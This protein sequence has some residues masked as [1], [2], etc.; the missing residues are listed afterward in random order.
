MTLAATAAVVGAA[1]VGLGLPLAAAAPL[2][3]AWLPRFP[4]SAPAG[5]ILAA[6]DMVWVVAV[7][8]HAPLGRFE[9]VK[10]YLY[11]AGPLAYAAMVLFMDEFLAA[12][13]LGGLLLLIA[14]PVLNVARW[15]DSPWRLVL[16]VIAYAWAVKGC[17][18]ILSPY[19]CRDGIAWL[20][21][22][23]ARCRA[24]GAAF[25]LTGV[26]LLALAARVY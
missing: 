20:T 7:V 26:L 25:V 13:A 21:A 6:V 14:N 5:W 11:V 18:L 12:R 17:I 10:P 22:S 9:P 23:E 19:R 16:T 4:R 15:H 8:L 3:R 2:C 24:A 1:V